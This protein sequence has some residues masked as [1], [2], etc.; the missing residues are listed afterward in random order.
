MLSTRTCKIC[1]EK[2]CVSSLSF[3]FGICNECLRERCVKLVEKGEFRKK[4]INKNE[5]LAAAMISAVNE[6]KELYE[7]EYELI[8]DETKRKIEEFGSE[9]F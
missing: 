7:D 8:S 1:E 9:L 2:N 3:Q 6:F 5:D 4:V